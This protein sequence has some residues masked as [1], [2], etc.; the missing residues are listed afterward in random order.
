MKLTTKVFAILIA[1]L[2][3][4]PLFIFQASA[5]TRNLVASGFNVER[6]SGDLVIYTS[7]YGATTR[8][9]DYG[10]EIVVVDNIITKFGATGNNEIP[11]NGFVI[12]GH[13]HENEGRSNVSAEPVCV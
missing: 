2:C 12:S 9:N 6:G 13:D 5:T 8:T 11:E 1:I 10:Y 3:V 7:D 4:F